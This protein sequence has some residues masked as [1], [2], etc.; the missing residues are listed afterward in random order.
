M[1]EPKDPMVQYFRQLA[2]CLEALGPAETAEVVAEVRSHLAEAVA[3]AG[4]DEAA[5]LASFGSPD[6]LAARIFEEREV[7]AGG[8]F[9]PEAP[10]WRRS[11]ALLIDVTFWLILLGVFFVQPLAA[12]WFDDP[13]G[14][15]WRIIGSLYLAA[16]MAG[17]VWWWAG[18]RNSRGHV[19]NGMYMTDLRRVSVGHTTRMVR[20]GD[21]PWES[22]LRRRRVAWAIRAML[23]LLFVYWFA[24]NVVWTTWVNGRADREREQQQMIDDAVRAT[25]SA[26]SHVSDV[27]RMVTAEAQPNDIEGY[28]APEAHDVPADLKAR[29]A[30][31]EIDSY[32]IWWVQLP[33]HPNGFFEPSSTYELL[34]LVQVAEYAEGSDSPTIYEYRVKLKTLAVWGNDDDSEWTGAWFIESAQLVQ[35]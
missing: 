17:S 29:L 33:D 9:L 12:T 23:L 26:V 30:A 25:S 1:A 35:Q 5:A 7:L 32:S 11:V 14:I 3:E 28:F 19:T 34:A 13:P 2:R 15:H 31:G 20:A 8:S 18:G 16:L 10:A 21:V 24:D 27:Y 4:G 6:V 22:P